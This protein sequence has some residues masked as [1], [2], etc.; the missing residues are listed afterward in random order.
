MG[1]D[2]Q[3]TSACYRNASN[4][5]I[6][7]IRYDFQFKLKKCL[8]LSVGSPVSPPMNL[9]FHPAKRTDCNEFREGTEKQRQTYPITIKKL[10]HFNPSLLLNFF[11]LFLFQMEVEQT[12][13]FHK[14]NRQCFWCFNRMNR[15][16]CG[17]VS[18]RI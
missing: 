14:A 15:V 7:R 17:Y 11:L 18:L 2:V 3:Q 9:S 13:R 6:Y 5:W 8:C 16:V 12:S 1:K 10:S 4:T